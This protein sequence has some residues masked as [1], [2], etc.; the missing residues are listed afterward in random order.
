MKLPLIF[1]INLFLIFPSF[2]QK[3]SASLDL[4]MSLPEGEYKT[5]NPDAGF[6]GRG[7][8]FYRPD[9]RLPFKVGIE[10]G[11]QVKGSV[12]QYFSGYI[13]GFYDEYKVNASN[14]IFSL[15]FLVRFQQEKRGKIKPF[16]DALAGWNV[17]FSTVSIERLTYFSAYNSSYSNSSKARWAFAYGAAAGVD[18]PLNRRD[19]IG[20]ELKCAYLIGST[21]TYLTDPQIDNTGQVFFSGKN[22]ATDMLIPQVGVRI[23][24][25]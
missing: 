19:D 16:L 8:F 7:N 21:T 15:F 1:F 6:G 24:I 3:F 10:P 11:L 14:N 4:Q 5:A 13:N 18:I 22:S 23:T 17:F 20:L 9:A 2:A 25:Q 12:S